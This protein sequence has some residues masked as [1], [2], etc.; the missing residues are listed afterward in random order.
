VE[1]NTLIKRYEATYDDSDFVVATRMGT[2]D[3]GPA[4]LWAPGVVPKPLEELSPVATVATRELASSQSPFD[5]N[6]TGTRGEDFSLTGPDDADSGD[7]GDTLNWLPIEALAD[8]PDS[9]ALPSTI[10]GLAPARVAVAMN[11]LTKHSTEKVLAKVF[12]GAG[13]EAWDADEEP[14]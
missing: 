10:D 12:A 11:G 1:L 7:I 4:I 6:S 13:D 9:A 14:L 5:L 2:D 3:R 8:G